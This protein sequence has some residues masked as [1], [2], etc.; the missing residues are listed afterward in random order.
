MD[1]NVRSGRGAAGIK[2]PQNQ[3]KESGN[4]GMGEPGNQGESPSP[5]LRFSVS[6]F[7]RTLL[8]AYPPYRCPLLWQLYEGCARISVLA[9]VQ[10]FCGPE[11]YPVRPERSDSGVEGRTGLSAQISDMSL[12]VI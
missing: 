5:F 4:R 8:L 9:H 11:P 6:L 12:R 3:E 7:L 2:Q 1:D 10:N